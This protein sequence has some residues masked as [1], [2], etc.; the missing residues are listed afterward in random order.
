MIICG[1]YGIGKS[2]YVAN[3]ERAG[4]LSTIEIDSSSIEKDGRPN[5]YSVYCDEAIGL[6]ESGKNVFISA[7][8][9]VL[10]YILNNAKANDVIVAIP[11]DSDG[12]EWLSDRLY[13]RFKQTK[14]LKDGKALYAS[15]VYG[16]KQIKDAKLLFLGTKSELII[17]KGKYLSDFIDDKIKEMKNN[18]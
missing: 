9:E 10:K 11:D 5:W 4:D 17:P 1:F 7:H 14:T 12:I 13:K 15:V 2:Y 3:K 18:G 8:P 6:S 16:E